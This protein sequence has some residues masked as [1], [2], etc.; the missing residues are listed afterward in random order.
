M[1]VVVV[2]TGEGQKGGVGGYC[3]ACER[4]KEKGDTETGLAALVEPGYDNYRRRR[5]PTF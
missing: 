5:G 4:R 3:F 1:N 2:K